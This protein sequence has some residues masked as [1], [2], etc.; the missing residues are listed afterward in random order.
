VIIS[1]EQ[2]AGALSAVGDA[3]PRSCQQFPT[4]DASVLIFLTNNQFAQGGAALFGGL[5]QLP[6]GL[7]RSIRP[8]VDA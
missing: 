4:T 5:L 3:Q 7:G 6:I 1:R 2:P 8:G